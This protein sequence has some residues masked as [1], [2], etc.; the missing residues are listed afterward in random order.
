M[1]DNRKDGTE[2][3]NSGG[4]NSSNNQKELTPEEKQKLLDEDKKLQDSIAAKK[5]EDKRLDQLIF[6]KRQAKRDLDNEGSEDDQSEDESEENE[7][8]EDDKSKKK[9][10]SSEVRKVLRE[11]NVKS[12]LKLI[13]KELPAL[14]DEIVYQRVKKFYGAG[15]LG[16]DSIEDILEDL[17]WAYQRAYPKSDKQDDNGVDADQVRRETASKMMNANNADLGGTSSNRTKESKDEVVLTDNQ[18]QVIAKLKRVD[19]KF[20]EK[21]YIEQLKNR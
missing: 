17:R 4:E 12:A 1:T 19:P 3:E 20:D 16:Q 21:K 11:N 5:L 18:K 7:E 10:T 14:T 15:S 6:E 8:E 13:V 9:D 2:K